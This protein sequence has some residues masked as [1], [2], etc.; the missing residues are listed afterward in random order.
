MTNIPT[1]HALFEKLFTTAVKLKSKGLV[2][3]SR[4][5]PDFR[6]TCDFI[7]TNAVDERPELQRQILN[8]CKKFY[9]QTLRF[10][11]N[12]FGTVTD[13]PA[14]RTQFV[15]HMINWVCSKTSCPAN[16]RGVTFG[17]LLQQYKKTHLPK[18]ELFNQFFDIYQY[19]QP[20][21]YIDDE[22]SEA[23]KICNYVASNAGLSERQS[24]SIVR[25]TTKFM[26]K[27]CEQ[28]PMKELL[29]RYVHQ[30]RKHFLK[31]S[32][33]SGQIKVDELLTMFKENA[34]DIYPR[35]L[36]PSE[37]ASMRPVPMRSSNSSASSSTASS[38]SSASVSSP[39]DT[40]N[41]YL[42]KENHSLQNQLKRKTDEFEDLKKENHSLQNQLKR[43]KFQKTELTN[44]MEI[45]MKNY[46]QHQKSDEA[47]RRVNE[48]QQRVNEGRQET[49]QQYQH[50]LE[51][52]KRMDRHVM[53]R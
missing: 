16:K 9:N 35:L 42:K 27:N 40:Q 47:Q 7:I 32:S 15:T 11:I 24:T 4:Q 5:G 12:H 51:Q 43:F 13:L 22:S 53:N 33:I 25:F 29:Y 8:G 48:A 50:K 3:C 52:W 46:S 6:N 18:V 34:H 39:R 28:Y 14:M 45:L 10:N 30:L 26:K 36:L 2:G 49:D 20:K 21:L 23:L 37:P 1:C 38:A 41:T 17:E 44:R 31:S 19:V